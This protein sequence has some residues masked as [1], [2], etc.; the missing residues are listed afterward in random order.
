MTIIMRIAF[1]FFCTFLSVH[2]M[3]LPDIERA[4]RIKRALRTTA[5][6]VG[7]GILTIGHVALTSWYAWQTHGVCD[8]DGQSYDWNSCDIEREQLRIMA[9]LNIFLGG[10]TCLLAITAR[11]RW[12]EARYARHEGV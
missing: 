6:C 7:T 5:A 4:Q 10:F 3:Q 9:P 12:R 11:E 8:Q 2:A 1:L